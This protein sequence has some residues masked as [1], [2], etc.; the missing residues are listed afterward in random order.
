MDNNQST[1]REPYNESISIKV[2]KSQ[3]E[4]LEHNKWIAAEIRNIVR[5]HIEIYVMKKE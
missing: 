3:K 1:H 5:Q 4:I 2:T